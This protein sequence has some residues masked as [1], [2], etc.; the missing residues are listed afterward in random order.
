M[1]MT[2]QIPALYNGVS[3]QPPTIRLGSQCDVQVNAWAT[4]VD[5]LRKRPPSIHS[6]RLTTSDLSSAYLHTI[7]RDTSER[8]QVIVTDGDI[9]VFDL[10]GNEK[11]VAFPDGKGYLDIPSGQTAEASFSLVTVADY[12]FVVNK[13]VTVLMDDLGSDTSDQA[14]Y[15]W[16]LNRSQADPTGMTENAQQL[17]YP[18]NPSG[19][20]YAG[21]KQSFQDL[22]DTAPEGAVWQI[23]GTN[24]SGFA[25]YYVRRTGGVWAESVKPGLKNRIDEQTLPHALV[26]KADGTFEFAPFSYAP[27]RV[28]DDLTNPNPTFVGRQIREVFFFKNRLAFCVD[29]NVVMSRVGDFGNFYRLTVVDLIDD[30]TIDTAASET[31]VTK[32]LFAVPLAGRL[33]L[34]ADQVQFRMSDGDV[35]TP[36]SVSLDVTTQFSMVQ[37][38]RP[39]PIGADVYFAS[40]NGDWA[41]IREY[42]VRNDVN[43]TD[44]TDVNQHCPRYVPAGIRKLFGSSEHNVLFV[45]TRSQKQRIYVYK[46]YWANDTDRLQGAWSYWEMLPGD[47][48]LSGSV[49][50]DTVYLVIRRS[51]GTYLESIPLYAG[52]Q[53]PGL[54]FQVYLDRRAVITGT[55]LS[56][57]DKT[58]FTL[59]YPVLTGDRAQVE[60]VRGGGFTGARGALIDPSQYEWI[61]S[62][63][64]RVPGNFTSASC[65]VG[66]K[67]TMRYTFSEQF[68]KNSQ[69][70]PTTTGRLQLRTWTVYYTDTA[71]FRTE[72]APYGNDP[73]VEAVVPA[74]LSDFTGRTLGDLSLRLGEPAFHEGAYSFQV[75]GNSDVAKVS[76]VN[77]SHLASNFQAAEWEG[78][79]QNRARTR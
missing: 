2:Q 62:T 55:Y 56:I 68:L 65:F 1:L 46:F 4:V 23:Q 58:E 33:M 59:P 47:D 30:E 53:A 7:N 25:S 43:T 6:T 34:F 71:F 26:R 24:E 69:G 16:W 66:M 72:V 19:S 42:Y 73:E 38:V 12:T 15:Y 9:R 41:I 51:D 3:Q 54:P 75:Y 36:T 22:P 48:I 8:Y 45:L 27:R 29:E 76:L 60:I 74:K 44:A 28:G 79:Y 17:Q 67:Y 70:A 10:A 64:V 63:T 14:S 13:T 61:D 40:E 35:L 50:D 18:P 32:L 31:K 57:P 39:E 20:Y 77:D 52:A 37:T 49:L 78:F 5:G 11:T 21:R